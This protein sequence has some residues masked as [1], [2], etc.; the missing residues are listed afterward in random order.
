[1]VKQGI[2]FDCDG[3]RDPISHVTEAYPTK[4]NCPLTKDL[5]IVCNAF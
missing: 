2:L 3:H 1:M 4:S 5:L